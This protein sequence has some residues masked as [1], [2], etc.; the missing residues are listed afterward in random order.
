ML[1]FLSVIDFISF[2]TY[3]TTLYEIQDVFFANAAVSD[4]MQTT[5]IAYSQLYVLQSQLRMGMPTDFKS[6]LTSLTLI[7]NYVYS[8]K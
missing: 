5:E 3:R 7:Q 8:L 2:L 6:T 4:I 1:V